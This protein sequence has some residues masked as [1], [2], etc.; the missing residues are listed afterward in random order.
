VEVTCSAEVLIPSAEASFT[1]PAIRVNTEGKLSLTDPAVKLSLDLRGA[2]L[3]AREA[4][5]REI[6]A[7]AHMV[8]E[9][10]RRS[11]SFQSLDV[12][13]N[14]VSSKSPLL[15]T[16]RPLEIEIS[17]KGTSNLRTGV[18]EAAPLHIRVPDLMEWAGSVKGH[19][20]TNPRVEFTGMDCRV[21][22]HHL[23]DFV[24]ENL[25]PDLRPFDLSGT[26]GLTGDL[27]LIRESENWQWECAAEAGFK[28]NPFSVSM[29]EIES[30][31]VLSGR[32]RV[33]GRFPD[34]RLS[35]KLEAAEGFLVTPVARLEPF[36]VSASLTG[37][38]PRL[39]VDEL[40][41]TIPRVSIGAAGQ[42]VHV[43][44]IRLA[45][46]KG[47]VDAG[48]KSI[49]LT[50]TS[51]DSSLC[52]A[53]GISLKA[54]P[55]EARFGIKGR[56]AGLL[57]GLQG[58]DLLPVGWRFKG[59]DTIQADAV[60]KQRGEWSLSAVFGIQQLE[61]QGPDPSWQGEKLCLKCEI[62]GKG[63]LKE[64]YLALTG[65]LKADRGEIL[66]DRFYFDLNTNGL[67]ADLKGSYQPEG[68]CFLLSDFQGGLKD[69]ISFSAQGALGHGGRQPSF[70]LSLQLPMTPVGPAFQVLVR[71]P[72]GR[73]M[74][75]LQGLETA[76][77]VSA[78]LR[79][80]GRETGWTLGGRI[81]WRKGTLT[82]KD[83]ALS[84]Q[85]IEL[86]LPLWLES[87]KG[88]GPAKGS[89]TG[90]LVVD[91][92]SV[93]RLPPQPLK[94]DLRAGSNSLA[95]EGPTVLKTQAGI[96]EIGPIRCEALLSSTPTVKTSL[97]M[98]GLDLR[99]VLSEIW[100]RPVE[101]TLKG[102]LDPVVFREGK[103][104][105]QGGIRANVFGGELL[106]PRLGAAGLTTSTPV[107]SLDAHWEGL[108]LS[109]LTKETSFGRIE[110]SLTG[111]VRNLE[112]A[113]GQPQRFDLLLETV[114]REGVAQRISV[115][116]VDNIAQIGGGQSP[117]MGAAGLLS[118]FFREFPYRKIGVSASLENDVFK[119]NGTIRED[120]MEYI[121]KRGSFSGVNVVNQNPDNRIRFKDMVKRI[122][123]V[124]SSKSGPVVQ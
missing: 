114:E 45:A 113:H 117:F 25:R 50:E 104:L 99:P 77:A 11:L 52:K 56:K 67:A 9:P 91:S 121:V 97:S 13:L 115:T 103:V 107:L 4:Q 76:G 89:M 8:L 96:L 49:L 90:R 86:D 34:I 73:E 6:S 57:E 26:V 21:R 47:L 5:V 95:V 123:R 23:L 30:R 1:A 35:L 116:A 64:P 51:L 70:H 17:G 124:G 71:E 69:I 39:E 10:G 65:S 93:P 33:D 74:P 14:G 48:R 68:K 20:G 63:R 24:P 84:L 38:W 29:K 60:L 122:Q 2:S 102:R 61:F 18:L 111:H 108:S 88:F 22:P 94:R 7:K 87:G 78:D 37:A 40:T 41:L 109:E 43:D 12:R 58:L 112:I 16:P 119:I 81:G 80:A 31:G 53:L 75:L 55:A 59:E 19:L 118:S 36:H 28:E 82:S 44:R 32:V 110:G 42:K 66:L 27:R 15:K 72:Y 92:L 100:D 62:Q 79:L 105:S 85:G 106:I 3:E 83:H 120:G 98:E 46:R 101:G 54:D